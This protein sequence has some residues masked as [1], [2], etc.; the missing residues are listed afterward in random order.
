MSRYNYLL[1]SSAGFNS[2]KSLANLLG[3]RFHSNPEKISKPFNVVLRYG[4]YSTS[5]LLENDTKINSVSSILNC[6]RKWL[7]KS[8]LEDSNILA[9]TY[10]PV[11][12][13]NASD[14]NWIE[15]NEKIENSGRVFLGRNRWHRGGQDIRIFTEKNSIPSNID[16]VVPFIRTS[17]E[18]R[19]HVINNEIVKI[20]RK[21][22]DNEP[23][24]GINIRSSFNGYYFTNA[25]IDKI[26]DGNALY[27]II[28][29]ISN[30]LGVMFFG[31]DIGWSPP[32]NSW[33]VFEVNSA[34]GL[35]SKTIDIYAKKLSKIL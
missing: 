23:Y 25:R 15:N 32:Y 18:Y 13:F 33:I 10:I 31:A 6:S 1:A 26:K 14:I 34:P 22:N 28:E 24:Y 19:V 27:D 8:F 3:L 7:L 16:F 21:R 30:K 12:N 5:S 9:P 35:N 17:R 4:N 2:G 20:F 11:E 29:K